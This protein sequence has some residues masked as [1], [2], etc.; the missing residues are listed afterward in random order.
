MDI[1]VKIVPDVLCPSSPQNSGAA[2]IGSDLSPDSSAKLYFYKFSVACAF[3]RT[4]NCPSCSPHI[5]GIRNMGVALL[6]PLTQEQ[7]C[8]AIDLCMRKADPLAVHLL[9][10]FSNSTSSSGEGEEESGS[11]AAR[12]AAVDLMHMQRYHRACL[13]LESEPHGEVD[14]H[15]LD[16]VSPTGDSSISNSAKNG[17]C[18]YDATQQVVPPDRWA[19]SS[20]GAWYLI[21]P[22]P[23]EAEILSRPLLTPQ[24]TLSDWWGQFIRR[25]AEEA[26]ALVHNL[27][28]QLRV[29]QAFIDGSSSPVLSAFAQASASTA[30]ATS[31]VQSATPVITPTQP[32]MSAQD[33]LSDML[34]SR[35]AGVIYHV[36]PH[37]NPAD[38][39]RV[40]DAMIL[41]SADR[42]V[43][44]QRNNS[45]PQKMKVGPG[46][47]GMSKIE[48]RAAC[49]AL[50]AASLT[51][52]TC[53]DEVVA[54]GCDGRKVVSLWGSFYAAWTYG[55]HYV[56]K[57]SLSSQRYAEIERELGGAPLLHLGI[58]AQAEHAAG[59][60]RLV[61]AHAAPRQLRLTEMLS[62]P[63]NIEAELIA[64]ALLGATA[65]STSAAAAADPEVT[66]P[67]AEGSEVDA[68]EQHSHAS[69]IH[70][71]PE[72][73]RPLGHA[74]HFFAGLAVGACLWKLECM[75][76][77]HEARTFILHTVAKSFCSTKSNS[78]GRSLVSPAPD[79]HM[80][81][82]ITAISVDPEGRWM[83]C[84]LVDEETN[85]AELP[86][87][88]RLMAPPLPVM[89]EALTPLMACDRNN[90]GRLELL[91]DSIL[92]AYAGWEVF[93]KKR[94]LSEGAMTEGRRVLTNNRF[95]SDRCKST[96]LSMYLQPVNLSGAS[97]FL[98]H[99][100]PGISAEAVM[101]GR[102]IWSASF[103][104]A[105]DGVSAAP[106]PHEAAKKQK[107]KKGKAAAKENLQ[108][109]SDGDIAD[110]AHQK[111][112]QLHQQLPAAAVAATAAAVEES[113]SPQHLLTNI[114]PK[115]LADQ[116]EAVV[117]AFYDSGGWT[118][119]VGVARVI[120]DMDNVSSKLFGASV[121]AR[122]T[123]CGDLPTPAESIYSSLWSTAPET[124]GSSRVCGTVTEGSSAP[125]GN[126][127]AQMQASQAT[128]A[129]LESGSGEGEGQ[130][131]LGHGVGHLLEQTSEKAAIET[132]TKTE[133]AAETVISASVK[134][135]LPKKK[136]KVQKAEVVATPVIPPVLVHLTN[137]GREA[138][139][140]AL[141][142]QFRSELLLNE[143]MTHVSTTGY[144]S[145]QRLE[146]FGDAV[147]DVVGISHI[148]DKVPLAQE[149]DLSQARSLCLSNVYLSIVAMHRLKLQRWIKCGS[150]DLERE[151]RNIRVEEG[152]LDRFWTPES[153]AKKLEPLPPK[154]ER[155]PKQ[156][157]AVVKRKVREKEV[158]KEGTGWRGAWGKSFRSCFSSCTGSTSAFDPARGEEEEA[159]EEDEE[160]EEEEEDEEFPPDKCTSS[161]KACADALEA[162]YGAM[163]IDSGGSLEA[164][165]RSMIHTR[166]LHEKVTVETE[167]CRE[168][169]VQ[170]MRLVVAKA[171]KK[172][173]DACVSNSCPKNK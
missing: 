39:V 128:L 16:W 96:G 23:H 69:A 8:H 112:P 122:K 59:T 67:A 38:V 62:F 45:V 138:I 167:A 2:E 28:V 15:E 140:H 22:L 158:E 103:V 152:Q 135:A 99:R 82:Q 53:G 46:M 151:L 87:P 48:F 47:R 9:P 156:K 25:S 86:V 85:A 100:P 21:V 149:G 166:V 58:R 56:S 153:V 80:G 57:G 120:L 148:F 146:F 130:Q 88:F 164:V 129:A 42:I 142:Y 170:A 29:N 162:L 108:S 116:V 75:L 78:S 41:V 154:T 72:L 74:R 64:A 34:V 40:T 159:G 107:K 71:L 54:A 24:R 10:L 30:D 1:K 83:E 147:I 50:L 7:L 84:C 126:A 55:E 93:V 19:S 70:L 143:A 144:R 13:C 114:P 137:S 92:K 160:E 115:Y 111:T 27:R 4:E 95:M 11:N 169:R 168:R 94:F 90:S 79:G 6:Q 20:H 60:H 141:Q 18:G 165:L 89:L 150:A 136:K 63:D 110:V 32:Y 171:T 5:N 12:V 101:Q 14:E 37:E 172:R 26:Q 105:G 109:A 127:M 36:S 81:R 31:A 125:E 123:E 173:P 102:S 118:L 119:G 124:L 52:D 117:G 43:D 157:K 68:A 106:L 51:S 35:G 17:G 33:D 44:L 121:L 76:L 134:K 98:Q 163:F 145:N 155:P 104:V 3:D 91:G 131:L 77:A 66:S 113:S 97:L 65:T 61:L 133:S 73:C 49:D 132:K 161:A 139:C